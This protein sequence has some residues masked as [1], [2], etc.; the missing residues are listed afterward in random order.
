MKFTLSRFLHKLQSQFGTRQNI[1]RSTSDFFFPFIPVFFSAH[2]IVGLNALNPRNIAWLGSDNFTGYLA[3]FYYLSDAWRFPLA[4]N[5]GY[6]LGNSTS[7]TYTGPSTIFLL[8]QKIF[9]VDP[10]IQL[11]GF[12][13]LLNVYLQVLLGIRIALR[14]TNSRITAY[15]FGILMLSPFLLMRIQWHFWLISHFL[16]LWAILVLIRYHQTK[17]IKLGNLSLL[18]IFSYL[19]NT[20][21]LM[22]VLILLTAG[23]IYARFIDKLELQAFSRIFGVISGS[24][25]ACLILVDG[26]F[27]TTSPYES[28]RSLLTP[29]YGAHPA[30]ILSFFQSNTGDSMYGNWGDHPKSLSDI[31]PA[32]GHIQGDY[33]GYAYLGLGGLLLLASGVYIFLRTH[34][35][36]RR[37]NEYWPYALAGFTTFLFA[38]SFRVGFGA[39]EKEFPFPL[40]A[41]YAL[42]LFRSSGRFMWILAYAVLVLSLLLLVKYLSPNKLKTVLSFLALIQLIELSG[43]L[44]QR[45]NFI[46]NFS[47]SGSVVSTIDSSHFQ[48]LSK[49]KSSVNFWPQTNA[50]IGW[51]YVSLLAAKNGL[52][53]NGVYTSR[54]NYFEMKRIENSTFRELCSN[55]LKAEIM[56]AVPIGNIT[57]LIS[58]GLKKEPSMIVRKVAI[59]I[60]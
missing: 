32:F 46:E 24:F 45:K 13:I 49:N 41:K 6:G 51:D 2:F 50:P 12:W 28:A 43:P 54:P 34:N 30:N 36:H 37:L 14:F 29:S 10:G 4:A 19:V 31:V 39:F 17:I 7:L 15:S 48:G 16:L 21:L 42:S 27:F 58:C 57:E 8:P 5:P 3:Q 52:N 18:I 35:S 11:F 1:L 38:I 53:T 25:V 47:S 9:N 56:Y 26:K 33:E 40:I 55:Q 44:Q 20:Y 22:M 23:L 59:Y 60:R